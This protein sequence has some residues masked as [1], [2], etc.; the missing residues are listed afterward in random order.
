MKPDELFS[1]IVNACPGFEAQV[2]EHIQDNDEILP[3]FLMG[4]VGS[5]VKS[6]FGQ[7]TSIASAPPSETELRRILEVLD[8]AMARG[9]SEIEE[10]IGVSFIE[11]IWNQS[12]FNDLRPMLGP[13][14][15]AELDRQLNWDDHSSHSMLVVATG[16]L[17]YA[18]LAALVILGVYKVIEWVI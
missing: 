3:H 16:L 7:S 18:T 11:Y 1:Q 14:L 9:G 8:S 13:A 15:A 12:H 4:D 10:L 5:L 6:Y 2:R 17:V